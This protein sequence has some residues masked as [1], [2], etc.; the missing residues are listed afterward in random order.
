MLQAVTCAGFGT[1]ATTQP[2]AASR[3]ELLLHALVAGKHWLVALPPL[4]GGGSWTLPPPVATAFSREERLELAGL[5][6][7]LAAYTDTDTAGNVCSTTYYHSLETTEK[8]QASARLGVAGTSLLASKL[9]GVPALH[10]VASIFAWL[11][12]PGGGNVRPDF[13]GQD[14]ALNW[15]VLESKGS[16]RNTAPNQFVA[17]AKM[18][19]TAVATVLGSPVASSV[20][21]VTMLRTVAGPIHAHVEDPPVDEADNKAVHLDN[22]ERAF[23]EE[24]RYGPFARAIAGSVP[25]V[26]SNLPGGMPARFFP[27]P[28]VGYIGLAERLATT[29]ESRIPSAGDPSL[30]EDLADDVEA[31]RTE[32]AAGLYAAEPRER[33]LGASPGPS[34]QD[35]RGGT[36]IIADEEY[37]V[38]VTGDGIAIAVVP[39]LLIEGPPG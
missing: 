33:R 9:L 3:L 19:A 37:E 13:A 39:G 22:F 31:A 15:V 21:S 38:A 24:Q 25:S 1:P 26:S 8:A 5:F 2:L 18:Q 4:P 34:D 30:R 32:V 6:L 11:G 10:H 28:G 23:L 36:S 20:A 12:M 7:M 35:E 14:T 29:V 16:A 27:L 17:D